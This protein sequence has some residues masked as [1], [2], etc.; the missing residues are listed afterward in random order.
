MVLR[1]PDETKCREYISVVLGSLDYQL[2]FIIYS[3]KPGD[4]AE[5]AHFATS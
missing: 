3:T 5:C 2:C 1:Y 4:A